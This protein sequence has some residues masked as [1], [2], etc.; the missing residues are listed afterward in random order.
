MSGDGE[1]LATVERRDDGYVTP[2]NRLKFWRR[3]EGGFTLKTCVDPPHN[4]QTTSLALGHTA[5]LTAVTT[6]T[7]CTV[8]VWMCGE[9]GDSWAQG[10]VLKHR[11]GPAYTSEISNDGSVIVVAFKGLVVLYATDTWDVKAEVPQSIQRVERIFLSGYYLLTSSKDLI[12]VWDL[13]S[14]S[15][16]WEGS[17]NVSYILPLPDKTF[18][19]F[20][21]RKSVTDAFLFGVKS[22]APLAVHKF[23][24]SGVV[25][26]ACVVDGGER[27]QRVVMLNSEHELYS[28]SH[29]SPPPLATTEREQL[30]TVTVFTQLL[31]IS[32]VSPAVIPDFKHNSSANVASSILNVSSNAL[33]PLSA[34][35]DNVLSDFLPSKTVPAK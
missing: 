29:S 28:L 18:L 25:V 9:E 20:V 31:N 21:S 15:L 3:Q 11:H 24:C 16:T 32:S 19:A 4:K 13:T 10:Q 14:L 8:K 6:S 30:D 22:S 2:E 12:S 7:D 17:A 5:C 1:W 26:G 33:P 23:V 34:I 35:C 27:E